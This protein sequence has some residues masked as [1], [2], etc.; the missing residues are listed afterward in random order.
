MYIL[1][2]FIQLLILSQIK[3]HTYIFFEFNFIANRSMDKH[4]TYSSD[5]MQMIVL[6]EKYLTV[7]PQ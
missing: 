7:D 1:H 2:Y 6:Q 3:A 4:F 5:I